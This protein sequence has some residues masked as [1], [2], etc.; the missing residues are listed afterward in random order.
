MESKN[1]KKF[2]VKKHLVNGDQTELIE[3]KKNKKAT[4]IKSNIIESRN[5]DYDITNNY[6][7]PP[8]HRMEK[9]PDIHHHIHSKKFREYCDHLL[10]PIIDKHATEMVKKLNYFQNRVIKN[11]SN[12]LK[13]KRRYV[14]GLRE[15]LKFAKLNKIR[16]LLVAPDIEAS[17]S[18]NQILHQIFTLLKE[19]DIYPIFILNRRKIGYLFGKSVSISVVSILNYDGVNEI[20]DRLLLHVEQ[21]KSNY[22]LN[23]HLTS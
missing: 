21:A 20:Y 15:A 14:L 16:C 7:N 6:F 12:L 13:S 18:T 2:I 17:N 9:Q 5:A 8:L 3:K 1:F 10:Y 19:N 22:Q 11:N 23:Y 4:P